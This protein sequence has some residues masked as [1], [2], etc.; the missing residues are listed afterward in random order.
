MMASDDIT[1][2]E[3]LDN[4]AAALIDAIAPAIMPIIVT[5]ERWLTKRP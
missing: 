2:R 5:L 4:L 1:M 3:A